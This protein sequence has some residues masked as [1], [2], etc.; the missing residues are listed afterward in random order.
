[1]LIGLTVASQMEMFSIGVIAD[2]GADFFTLFSSKNEKGDQNDYVSLEDIKKKWGEIDS[3]KEG[4]I[5]KTDVQS[6]MIKREQNNPLKKIMYQIKITFHLQYHLKAF[7]ALLLFVAVTKA[8][9][10]FFSRYS[11]QILSIRISQDLRQQY[12]DHI[13][14][15]R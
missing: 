14:H 7:I 2:T 3:E 8:F 9:F 13:Q 10:L 5:T 11:S 15:H 4:M 12:F 6:Y 1:M